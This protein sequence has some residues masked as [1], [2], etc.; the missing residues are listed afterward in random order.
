MTPMFLCWLPLLIRPFW[1]SYYFLYHFFGK[2]LV[3]AHPILCSLTNACMCTL[4]NP[5]THVHTRARTHKHAHAQVCARRL[6]C[7]LIIFRDFRR[8]S[9]NPWDFSYRSRGLAI[10]NI[11]ICDTSI[12]CSCEWLTAHFGMSCNLIIWFYM[13]MHG[14]LICSFLMLSGNNVN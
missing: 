3:I 11:L 12:F 9:L 5:R 14:S 2:R 1:L 7:A 4:A 10:S 13:H 8:R 6:K